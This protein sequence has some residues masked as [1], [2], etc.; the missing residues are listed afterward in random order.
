MPCIYPSLQQETIGHFAVAMSWPLRQV[1]HRRERRGWS[2]SPAFLSIAHGSALGRRFSSPPFPISRFSPSAPRI[3][4]LKISPLSLSRLLFIYL[5][6]LSFALLFFLL[7]LFLGCFNDGAL[8]EN[9]VRA[10]RYLYQTPLSLSCIGF[11]YVVLV[12]MKGATK[13]GLV[14]WSISS[15][16]RSR[17]L[18]SKNKKV[19]IEQLSFFNSEN[20]SIL[21]LTATLIYKKI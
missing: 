3:F 7:P 2:N 1:F 13:N 8:I 14:T 15:S 19:L 5:P 16:P 4:H 12:W 20:T 11:L 18:F 21:R 6:F 17:F 9:C 10:E